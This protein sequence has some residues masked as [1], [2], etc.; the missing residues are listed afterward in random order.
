[1]QYELEERSV[2]GFITLRPG[3]DN[4][5]RLANWQTIIAGWLGGW[6]EVGGGRTE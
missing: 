5:A 2:Q 6:M 4:S 1:M 3:G